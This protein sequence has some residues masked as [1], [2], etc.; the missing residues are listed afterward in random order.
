[1]RTQQVGALAVK[2]ERD[3]QACQEPSR[4]TGRSCP[5]RVCSLCQADGLHSCHTSA[6]WRTKGALLPGPPGLHARASESES[7]RRA[8][9][10]ALPQKEEARARRSKCGLIAPRGG[11]SRLR[12]ACSSSA[13]PLRVQQRRSGTLASSSLLQATAAAMAGRAGSPTM[14]NPQAPVPVFPQVCAPPASVT[15]AE[16]AS[17]PDRA[18][19]I[20]RSTS[21]TARCS[22]ANSR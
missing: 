17:A 5:W 9:V 19:M 16:I 13:P 3:T 7:E 11:N 4:R 2:C 1:M 21:G 18:G 12:F 22:S 14:A 10:A 8:P 15:H 6:A 20:G